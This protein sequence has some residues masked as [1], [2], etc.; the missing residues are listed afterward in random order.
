LKELLDIVQRDGQQ[1]LNIPNQAILF[2]TFSLG[3]LIRNDPS[4]ETFYKATQSVLLNVFSETT[5]ESTI[6]A[7]LTCLYQLTT[8]QTSASWNTF[9]IVV[10]IAQALGCI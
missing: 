3:A 1:C 10:R 4:A 2:M 7:F 9:G 5:I 8:G 6:V